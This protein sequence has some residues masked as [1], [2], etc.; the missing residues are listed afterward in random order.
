MIEKDKFDR[1]A[2]K[3]ERAAE[4]ENKQDARDNV[5]WRE[6]MGEGS[7]DREIQKEK[8]RQSSSSESEEDEEYDTSRIPVRQKKR[9]AL[10]IKRL[11]QDP[12]HHVRGGIIFHKGKA[13]Y[14]LTPVLQHFFGQEK[15]SS[16]KARKL[17]QHFR[18]TQKET[19]VS[20]RAPRR[21]Y[22]P[23]LIESWKKLGL[24]VS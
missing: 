6:K 7:K 10:F 19:A 13:R 22:H 9:A 5:E 24:R 20:K 16:A 3:G 1:L 12:L 18:L 23:D 8:E 4:I 11:S 2:N 15:L 17:S 21:T 14:K